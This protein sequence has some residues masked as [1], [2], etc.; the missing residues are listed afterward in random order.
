MSPP[1]RSS[2][3]PLATA[4]GSGRDSGSIVVVVG[5]DVVVVDGAA[6]VDGP[7]PPGLD[8]VGP[9]VV[10][11]LVGLV[12]LEVGAEVGEVVGPGVPPPGEL[13]G[14]ELGGGDVTAVVVDPPPEPLVV[15]VAPPPPPLAVVVVGPDEGVVV[16]V[17]PV[18]PR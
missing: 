11:P 12:E 6:V 7:E 15:D 3:A 16:G 4:R 8:V 10:G 2:R 9:V 18:V 14:D 1:P 17:G 13:V 5:A